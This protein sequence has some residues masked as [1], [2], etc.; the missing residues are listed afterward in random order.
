[1]LKLMLSAPFRFLGFVVIRKKMTLIVDADI[2]TANLLSIRFE[3]FPLMTRK[4]TILI[5][6]G[7]S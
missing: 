6:D 4:V 2:E 7:V 3:N 1:M 5:M